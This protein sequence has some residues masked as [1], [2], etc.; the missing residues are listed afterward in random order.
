M[1]KVCANA[2]KTIL[3]TTSLG[4]R[5][6]VQSIGNRCSGSIFDCAKPVEIPTGGHKILYEVD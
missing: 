6:V 5:M 4:G 1:L 3:R 2:E